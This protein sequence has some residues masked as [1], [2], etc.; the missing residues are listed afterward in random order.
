[1]IRSDLSNNRPI[2]TL[3]FLAK[4]MERAV[5]WQLQPHL[6]SNNI[7]DE[8]QSGFRPGRGT[9]TTM[10]KVKDDCLW[11]MDND[12]ASAL[13]LLDLSAAFDTVDHARLLERLVSVAGLED[14]ALT[15]MA[16]FLQNRTQRV[17]LGTYYSS[18]SSL[19]CGVPQGSALSPI[20]FNIYIRPLLYIIQ[21][22]NLRFHV[23][24][25]DTQIYFKLPK[26]E[27]VQVDLASCLEEIQSW[28]GANYLKLNGSKT[29]CIII[30]NQSKTSLTDFPSWPASFMPSPTLATQVRDLGIIVDSKLSLK[31]QV[32][33][34]VSAC[35]YQLKLL[36]STFHFIDEVDKVHVINAFIGSRLDYCNALYM[37]CPK[38]L[39][40]KLQLIQNAAARLLTGVGRRDHITPSLKALHW[41]PV[42]ERVLFKVG[43]IVHKAI[44]KIGPGYLQET[45]TCY[46]PNR[47]L[48]SADQ[49]NLIVPKFRRTRC[50]GRTLDAQGSTFWNS[51]PLY[52]RRE[53]DLL[54]FRTFL[55]TFLFF[56]VYGPN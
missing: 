38:T 46:V 20:L 21:R 15:W 29:E 14:M 47:S 30:S 52:I 22:H 25:D 3:P 37:G 4:I 51:L 17:R 53:K 34:V 8:Y 55:K 26:N 43:C 39:L 1:M 35:Y 48:R 36:R 32:N 19:S 16:S 40:H 33:Q 41:L 45:F 24:A 44:H 6:E 50:G 18:N 56:Q 11:A 10:I 13:I 54:K 31:A 23:Y 28:M 27:K 42:A 5:V 2:S 49:A 9:E 12:E 7:F